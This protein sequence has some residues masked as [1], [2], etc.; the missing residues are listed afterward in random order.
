MPFVF[1]IFYL[2]MLVNKFLVLRCCPAHYYHIGYRVM[3]FDMFFVLLFLNCTPFW[4]SHVFSYLYHCMHHRWNK[5]QVR[6]WL[7][8]CVWVPFL[9][10]RLEDILKH[11]HNVLMSKCLFWDELDHSENALLIPLISLLKMWTA[12]INH[13]IDMKCHIL[14][15]FTH[16]SPVPLIK[17][18]TWT[19]RRSFIRDIVGCEEHEKS[20]LIN[21]V[22]I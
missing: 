17:Y 2:I 6:S 16:L 20:S 5:R 4:S 19:K 14:R 1:L 13:F 9:F 7:L 8:P 18:D 3:V 15:I 22:N 12:H 10:W 11:V 21:F